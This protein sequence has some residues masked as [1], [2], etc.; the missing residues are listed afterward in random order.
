MIFAFLTQISSHMRQLIFLLFW[1]KYLSFPGNNF[2]NLDLFNV[3]TRMG[4]FDPV[5]VY[6]I[7]L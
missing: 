3:P 1:L 4:L 2:G 5:F 7:Y 6:S